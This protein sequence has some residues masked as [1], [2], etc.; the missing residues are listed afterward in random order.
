MALVEPVRDAP[1]ATA[2]LGSE[3]ALVIADYHAGVEE[4]L[5]RDGVELESRGP[6]RRAR[7]RSLIDRTGA[8]RVLFLGDLGNHIGEP[9]GAELEEPL[10]L[11]HDLHDVAVTLVPGNHDGRLGDVLE[12]DIADGDGVVFG[13]VGFVHGHSWPSE[14]VLDADVLAVGHEHPTVRLTDEVGGSRIERVWL[15]GPLSSDPFETHAG[16]DTVPVADADLVVFPGFNDL[17]GGTWV[18]VD[19]QDFLSPFLPDACPDADAYLLDG[20]RLGPFRAV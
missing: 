12:F 5:R 13:S 10:E 3:T 7:V 20:T 6:D 17:V 19:E 8:D 11:E 16:T 9:S 15:R 2:D 14:A 18:N 1:A 4:Q